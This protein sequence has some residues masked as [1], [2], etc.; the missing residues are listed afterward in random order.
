MLFLLNILDNKILTLK[1]FVLFSK[2]ITKNPVV[3]LTLLSGILILS[4]VFVLIRTAK[5]INLK[6][7][8][9]Y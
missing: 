4:V 6:L 1:L 2:Q 9:L 3:Y 5:P 8:I 7:N